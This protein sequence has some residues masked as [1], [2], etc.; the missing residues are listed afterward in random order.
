MKLK[1]WIR[2]ARGNRPPE[3]TYVDAADAPTAPE[4]PYRARMAMAD[5]THHST[6]DGIDVN[7][8]EVVTGRL[9]LLYRIHCPCGHRWDATEFH[10]MTLCPK[11]ERAVLVEAPTLPPG[12]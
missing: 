2:D 7:E 4:G 11:C 3:E 5:T 10:R 9:E 8:R 1:D 6:P 12:K